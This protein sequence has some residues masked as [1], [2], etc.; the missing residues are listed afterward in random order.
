MCQGVACECGSG[1][2]G[3][4]AQGCS[5]CRA[6][7]AQCGPRRA[8][9]PRARVGS[10]RLARATSSRGAAAAWPHRAGASR[11]VV[12]FS[13]ER[14]GDLAS[15]I[16]IET[17]EQRVEVPVTAQVLAEASFDAIAAGRRGVSPF[18]GSRAASR[19]A[20]GSGSTA[21]SRPLAARMTRGALPQ[22][23]TASRQ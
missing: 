1:R 14:A 22:T 20:S 18:N 6:H 17:S 3:P 11:V 2:P 8:A 7:A 10:R 12:A 21:L 13:C 5:P 4:P 15:L 19:A 9:L 16:V 23:P